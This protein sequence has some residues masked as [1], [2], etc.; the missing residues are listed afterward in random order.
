MKTKNTNI[1]AC[2]IKFKI[3][4]YNIKY[5]LL[6]YFGLEFFECVSLCICCNH[7]MPLHLL[8]H[9]RT[10]HLLQPPKE[11]ENRVEFF[12]SID[13][14]IYLCM[15]KSILKFY[16]YLEGTFMKK[17]VEL[18]YNNKLKFI[19]WTLKHSLTHFSVQWKVIC[20]KNTLQSRSNW[21]RLSWRKKITLIIKVSTFT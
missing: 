21:P 16:S 13:R 12:F 19:I 1:N 11:T 4:K 15:Q 20:F 3:K 8:Q 10:M 9:R 18:L 7:Q 17:T 5:I 2:N 14:I 6:I